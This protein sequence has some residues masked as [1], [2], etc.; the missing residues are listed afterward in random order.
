MLEH[1]VEP[2]VTPGFGCRRGSAVSCA[3]AVGHRDDEMLAACTA[4]AG[5]S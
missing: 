2:V 1:R 4:T 3:D 5:S